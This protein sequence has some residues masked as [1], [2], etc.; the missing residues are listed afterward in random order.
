MTSLLQMKLLSK[1]SITQEIWNALNGA[2]RITLDSAPIFS[3]WQNILT[4][5][6]G[7]KRF[8]VLIIPLGPLPLQATVAISGFNMRY[9]IAYY[10]RHLWCKRSY[11]NTP[12]HMQQVST[13]GDSSI[14]KEHIF[15]IIVLK[16]F[17]P[18]T[19]FIES[20]KGNR[21]VHACPWQTKNIRPTGPGMWWKSELNSSSEYK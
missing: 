5:V 19:R 6:Q 1:A 16:N 8:V 4:R 3:R 15:F 10:I 12:W 14:S 7:M 21:L 11:H 20:G 9:A 2:S 13:T 17:Q 18:P